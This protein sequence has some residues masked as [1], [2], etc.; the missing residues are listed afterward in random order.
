MPLRACFGEV[1]GSA[2][3][4][5]VVVVVAAEETGCR[6]RELRRGGEVL[7]RGAD[8][9]ALRLA[10]VL[11]FPG[12]VDLPRS[13]RPVGVFSRFVGVTARPAGLQGLLSGF[14]GFPFA[15]FLDENG[16]FARVEGKLEESDEPPL[17]RFVAL[18]RRDA[19]GRSDGL[20]VCD[21]W[22][23]GLTPFMVFTFVSAKSL[24][25]RL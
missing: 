3:L 15:S 22:N 9:Y 25:L 6:G 21:F 5:F 14:G 2:C 8:M 18:G 1:E 11:I 16:E 20:R 7:G 13:P 4:G 17:R 24:W 12:L 10:L 19:E 23:D